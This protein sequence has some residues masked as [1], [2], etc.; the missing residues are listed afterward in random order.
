MVNNLTMSYAVN[1]LSYLQKLQ[2]KRLLK[3]TLGV[4]LDDR[5]SKLNEDLPYLYDPLKKRRKEDR[6]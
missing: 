4:Y 2:L 5:N 3:Y 1:L 6:T